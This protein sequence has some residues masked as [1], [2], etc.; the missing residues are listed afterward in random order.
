MAVLPGMASAPSPANSGW[1][2]RNMAVL[3]NASPMP[4]ASAPTTQPDQS[5]VP[6][7]AVV[8]LSQLAHPPPAHRAHMLADE[9]TA[10]AEKSGGSAVMDLF[11]GIGEGVSELVHR[12]PPMAH[13]PMR[14]QFPTPGGMG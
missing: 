11:G 6:P 5:P 10:L 7:V 2:S 1:R 13:R 3:H 4:S 9:P 14:H 8:S 12:P